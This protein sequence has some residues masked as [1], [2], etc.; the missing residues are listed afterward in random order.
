MMVAFAIWCLAAT[1]LMLP[2]M[3]FKTGAG[4]VGIT[5]FTGV[6]ISLFWLIITSQKCLLLLMLVTVDNFQALQFFFDIFENAS[7][8]AEDAF[9][10]LIT[11]ND[12]TAK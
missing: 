11:C 12:V 1:S 4:V 3:T 2:L 8:A 6:N 10:V 7:Q 9:M 5:I